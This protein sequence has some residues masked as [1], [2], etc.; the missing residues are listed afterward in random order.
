MMYRPPS[1]RRPSVRSLVDSSDHF[2]E[3][4]KP[5]TPVYEGREI[6]GES[7]LVLKGPENARDRFYA[8][9]LDGRFHSACELCRLGDPGDWI[10]SLSSLLKEDLKFERRSSSFRLVRWSNLTLSELIF[11]VDVSR[12]ENVNSDREHTIRKTEPRR[13]RPVL[14]SIT[15][16]SEDDSSGLDLNS[17][18]ETDVVEG[19]GVLHIAE[20]DSDLVLPAK[21]THAGKFC[22]LAKSEAGKT[23]LSMV[24]AEEFAKHNPTLA[25]A[26]IDPTGSWYGLNGMTEGA[27][28]R[29][30]SLLLGGKHGEL[31]IGPSDGVACASVVMSLHPRPV[32]FDLSS[33]SPS[34]Q[35]EFM[36]GFG[37][38][39]YSSNKKAVHLFV[40]EADEFSPQRLD[41]SSLHQK[42][43][44]VV[45]DRLVRRG[46]VKGIGVTLIT[47][48][49]A[50]IH[51]NVIS[52][53]EGLF[54]L[55]LFSPQDLSA[56]S[57]WM[58]HGTAR[59]S[60][61][62]CLNALPDLDKGSAFLVQGGGSKKV[63]RFKVRSKLSLDTSRTRTVD[64]DLDTN[65]PVLLRV[66]EEVLESVKLILKTSDPVAS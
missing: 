9:M 31:S 4:E 45:M 37:E 12:N 40:D 60:R 5:S 66:P 34:E 43:S 38:R 2:E 17:D 46:R 7:E 27:S 59:N 6:I 11:G 33:M 54:L 15:G 57:A 41:P 3:P 19:G 63:R 1:G 10:R 32:I 55:N 44:L 49:P 50:V 21:K 16:S 62:A 23:Y 25:F 53:V 64:D 36:V 61:I 65:R 52:Q 35:H 13:P 39:L 28:E 51:K 8:L 30:V 24:L 48:R 22:V 26:V 58:E 20:N 42:K 14:G 18:Q 29:I 47:Q 56:V